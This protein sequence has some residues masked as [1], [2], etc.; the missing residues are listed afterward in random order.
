MRCEHRLFEMVPGVSLEGTVLKTEP[1]DCEEVMKRVTSALGAAPTD[2]ELDLHLPMQ[3]SHE[4]VEMVIASI[5]SF[6]PCY[7]FPP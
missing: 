6:P 4:A 5:S 3:P 2:A 1:L 7:S